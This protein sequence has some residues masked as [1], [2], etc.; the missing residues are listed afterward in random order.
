M[1]EAPEGAG[2]MVEAPEGAGV[3]VATGA[4]MVRAERAVTRSRMHAQQKQACICIC[5]MHA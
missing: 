5:G 1:E 3:M 2:V 4:V